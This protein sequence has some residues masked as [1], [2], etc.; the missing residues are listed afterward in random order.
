[1]G[2]D[3]DELA[4]WIDQLLDFEDRKEDLRKAANGFGR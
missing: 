1:M 4:W 2:M 3:A